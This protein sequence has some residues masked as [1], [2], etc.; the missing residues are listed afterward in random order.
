M[1]EGGG[2]HIFLWRH[3]RARRAPRREQ[4]LCRT[5][6]PRYEKTVEGNH[7]A[8]IEDSLPSTKEPCLQRDEHCEPTKDFCDYRHLFCGRVETRYSDE[9][10]Q[11]AKNSK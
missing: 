8:S 1:Q 5:I 9:A 7:S 3:R 11:H 4:S 2:F 6:A 10:E